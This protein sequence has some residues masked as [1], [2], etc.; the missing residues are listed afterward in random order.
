LSHDSKAVDLGRMNDGAPVLFNTDFRRFISG[1]TSVRPEIPSSDGLR[2]SYGTKLSSIKSISDEVIYHPVRYKIL[3]GREAEKNLQATF[4]IVKNPAV[5]IN[6]N[7]LKVRIINSINDFFDVQNWD[8]GDKF[9]LGELITYVLSSVAPDLSNIIIVPRQ[10]GQAIGDIFEIRSR[11]D[12]IF[13]SGAT[14][15]DIEIV[16]SLNS[17]QINVRY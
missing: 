2:I 13:V 15:D 14:V 1:E 17:S 11:P 9:Y 3:F 4:K 7:D 16:S 5:S 6:D 8:F 12:E 10:T